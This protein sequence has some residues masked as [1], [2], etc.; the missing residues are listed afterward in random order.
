MTTKVFNSKKA[1]YN[2]QQLWLNPVD[3]TVYATERAPT[4]SFAEAGGVPIY[5]F[6]AH[7]NGVK[8]AK[9]SLGA[10]NSYMH[11]A[12]VDS[13]FKSLAEEYISDVKAG[14]RQRMAALRS[15]TNAAVDIVN[16]W[17]TVLGKQDRTYAGKNLAKE[18]AVPNLLISID[19][20]TKFSGMTQLDEGQLGQLKELTYSRQTFEANKYGLKFVI[21]EEA[22][23]K[24][25]HNVLQDSIQVASNKVEQ[26]QSFDVI[27]QAELN[28]T[29]AAAGL[30]DAFDTNTDHSSTSPLVDL[31]I[32]QLNIEGSGVGGK[33]TRV[34][35]HQ[36]DY[37]KYLANTNVR[38][39]ASTSP[40]PV[41]F[42]PGTSELAGFPGLGLVL[43]NSIE[44]GHVHI[45]DTEKEPNI[46]L[47]QGPQRLGSA[48]D[49]ETGDDKYFII[50]Y[51]LAARIQPETGRTITGVNTPLDWS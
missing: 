36:I 41:T 16:V 5:D 30:W 22:Q 7:F 46:A 35:M 8:M 25:V 44:Q 27:A 11:D 33:A 45:V 14:G 13:E 29:Q 39:V 3:N 4:H 47:F 42:E 24:N 40:V 34:G 17:E 18:I 28:T 1:D 32:A 51:H 26:R 50:D 37:A 20:A 19:T 21:H 12:F 15:P 2:G 10:N 38:G 49:E 23:L 48:H 31:G 43:D 9:D 6:N